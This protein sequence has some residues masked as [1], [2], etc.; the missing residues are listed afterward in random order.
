MN[1]LK[2]LITLSMTLV[3]LVTIGCKPDS[4]G[5]TSGG[6]RETFHMNRASN[7]FASADSGSDGVGG[8]S[9]DGGQSSWF[10]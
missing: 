2:T 8:P 4:R 1:H 10:N 3:L 7:S 5:V 9:F 6:L